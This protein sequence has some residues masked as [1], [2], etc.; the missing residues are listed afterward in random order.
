M[1]RP[2]RAGWALGL[3]LFA[4]AWSIALVG[5]VFVVPAYNDGS[6]LAQENGA[7]MAI[8]AAVPAILAVA[9]F[10]GL[11][12]RCAHGS[13]RGSALAWSAIIVL[14]AFSVVAMWSIGMFSFV[15][16]LAL[17]AGAALTPKPVH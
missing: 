12:R 5:A 10:A 3:S 11:R 2:R 9:G 16:A 8:P 17:L 15:A 4:V 1:A 14:L 6:T 7:W 13:R